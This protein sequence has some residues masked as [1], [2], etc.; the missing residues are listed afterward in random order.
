MRGRL[1]GIVA[2]QQSEPS[3]R[4]LPEVMAMEL[5]PR[6][7]HGQ[8]VA[9][10]RSCHPMDEIATAWPCFRARQHVSQRG[11]DWLL[12]LACSRDGIFRQHTANPTRWH[13]S[14]ELA[15][16]GVGLTVPPPILQFN[17]AREE[18]VGDK[19][20]ASARAFARIAA[21]RKNSHFRR[22]GIG[23]RIRPQ[24]VMHAF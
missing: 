17:A 14:C 13:L 16:W 21:I 7:W 12:G 3:G 4:A 2:T 19:S 18:C 11:A 5:R 24:G 1:S 22:A 8:A 23:A 15:R 20:S 10:I 6:G 9:P